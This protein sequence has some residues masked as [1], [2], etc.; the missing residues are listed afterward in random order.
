MSATIISPDE[1]CHTLGIPRDQAEFID[2]PSTFSPE[3]RPNYYLPR[4]NITKKTEVE[5]RPKAIV[6]LDNEILD[7]HPNDKV[8][9]HTVSYGYAQQVYSMSRHR[10][11]MITYDCARDRKVKLDEFKDAPPGAILVASSMDRGIDLPGD[12]CRVIVVMKVPFLNLGDKQI[13]TRLH[14]DKKG[15]QL[16]FNVN[17]I[18]TLIQMTGRGMRSQED[19]CETYILDAQFGRLYRQNKYLFPAWWREALHMPKP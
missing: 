9:V 17:A 15:G 1:M 11:R 2:L 19:Y 3:R 5:E 14:S 8:L 10:D 13:S 6:A 7:K 16:W 12:Q 4:A 18:R